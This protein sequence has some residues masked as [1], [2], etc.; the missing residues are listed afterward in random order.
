MRA[1]H[2]IVPGGKLNVAV[3]P[4]PY[5]RDCLTGQQRLPAGPQ[6]PAFLFGQTSPHPVWLPHGQRVAATLL[7]DGATLTYR[8]GGATGRRC[9]GLPVGIKK[10][11]AVQ[12]LAGS[13]ELPIPLACDR[14]RK[15]SSIR[16]LQTPSSLV[17]LLAGQDTHC[18]V[19]ANLTRAP[20]NAPLTNC[21]GGWRKVSIT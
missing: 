16:H 8:L 13:P 12:A 14:L 5:G 15:S 6:L 7:Q 21:G 2:P 19:A 1:H 17:G 11:A 3:T 10:H 4:P 20:P 9:G 18:A